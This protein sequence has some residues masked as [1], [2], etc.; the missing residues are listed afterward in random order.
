[1]VNLLKLFTQRKS[2]AHT[3]LSSKKKEGDRFEC[4]VQVIRMGVQLAL[5]QHGHFGQSQRL[6]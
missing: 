2:T 1:M 6:C 3:Y 5:I 4:A